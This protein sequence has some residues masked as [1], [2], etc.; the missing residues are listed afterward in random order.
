MTTKQQLEAQVS[1]LKNDV[2]VLL[3]T[4][5]SI[6]TTPSAQYMARSQSRESESSHSTMTATKLQPECG[7]GM[8]CSR[9][10]KML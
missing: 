8:R 4:L 7:Q 1:D 2:D 10:L 6:R 5:A 3:A 9:E